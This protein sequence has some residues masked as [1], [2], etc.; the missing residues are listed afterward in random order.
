MHNKKIMGG[1]VALAATVV[2]VGGTLAWFTDSE[3]ILNSFNTGKVD[4][5]IEE[6]FIEPAD[7]TPG[8]TTNKDVKI[9]N[10][11][12]SDAFIRVKLEK[13]WY[14]GDTK[15]ELSTDNIEV[16]LVNSNT[17]P[18]NGS[19]VYNDADGY[20]YYIGI[21]APDATTNQL[22]D[23]VKFVPGNNDNNYAG[24]KADVNV[25]AE[26]IQITNDAY[27]DAWKPVPQDI[28]NALDSLISK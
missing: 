22:V 20:Y 14:D 19:W 1:A 3:T 25:V 24:K 17:T 11:G 8:T 13:A 21:V 27:K 15:T 26:A 18:T 12:K 16:T 4:I 2:L 28:Q 23:A 9:K 7:W 5:A 6:T 10:E